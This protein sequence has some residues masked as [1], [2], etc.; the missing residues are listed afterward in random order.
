MKPNTFK[1]YLNHHSLR[2]L[3]GHSLLT[4]PPLCAVLIMV[5]GEVDLLM[6]PPLLGI[7][8]WVLVLPVTYTIARPSKERVAIDALSGGLLMLCLCSM[9]ASLNDMR[10]KELLR[11]PVSK[12]QEERQP[13]RIE[14]IP[15]W[16][17]AKT[18]YVDRSYSVLH[19]G[20][21]K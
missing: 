4:L 3:I 18:P 6:L 7:M 20:S 19:T 17:G 8:G 15:L 10:L 1:N 5:V 9:T 12:G 13:L 21:K 11:A 16:K 2:L 14:E